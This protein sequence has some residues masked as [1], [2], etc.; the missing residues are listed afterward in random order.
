MDRGVIREINIIDK[1]LIRAG[2]LHE[3][4]GEVRRAGGCKVTLSIN[5]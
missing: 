1:H 4:T 3:R 2:E 5:C